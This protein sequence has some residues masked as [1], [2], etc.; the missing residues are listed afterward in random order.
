MRP[1]FV[2]PS[3][4]SVDGPLRFP[5]ARERG[6]PCALLLQAPEELLFFDAGLTKPIDSPSS[7]GGVPVLVKYSLS[8]V[9]SLLTCEGDS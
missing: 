8:T 7:L 3:D 2:V 1:L 5:E 9:E 6:L 4:P